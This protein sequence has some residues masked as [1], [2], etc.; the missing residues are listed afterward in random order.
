MECLGGGGRLLGARNGWAS[1][2]HCGEVA[3]G[4]TLVALV[5]EFENR[6]T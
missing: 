6:L 1:W 5:Y 4:W 2:E 3:Y